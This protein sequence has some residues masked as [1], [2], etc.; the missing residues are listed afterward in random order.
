MEKSRRNEC[1]SELEEIRKCGMK[2]FSIQVDESNFF[3]WQALL[4]PD[5]PPYDKAAYRVEILFPADYPFKPPKV[6]FKTK[7]YHPNVDENGQICLSLISSENW[8]PATRVHQVIQCLI[9]LVNCP[10]PEHPLRADLAEEYYK[11]R[12]KFLKTAEEFSKR[13]GEKRPVD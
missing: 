9:S 4:F 12:K 13:Y 2:S 11:D 5:N 10:E 8:K 3:T 6:V 7:I 1:S